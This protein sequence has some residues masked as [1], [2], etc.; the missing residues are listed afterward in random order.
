MNKYGILQGMKAVRQ[1]SKITKVAVIVLAVVA[2]L[3]P[4][5]ASAASSSHIREAQQIM[6]KPVFRLV[7]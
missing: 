4:Q 6:T 2:I 7:P 1:L 3:I 5:D